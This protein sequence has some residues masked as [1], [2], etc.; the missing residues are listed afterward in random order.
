VVAET[1]SRGKKRS[2][3]ATI[4]EVSEFPMEAST[5][6]KDV[7]KQR[8]GQLPRRHKKPCNLTREG[9]LRVLTMIGEGEEGGRGE[10]KGRRQKI[11]PPLVL[12]PPLS[13]SP[14]SHVIMLPVP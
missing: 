2:T 14:L 8:A 6:N 7:K 12:S 5:V 9:E 10:K 1:Q 3:Q 11:V 4:N 13:F